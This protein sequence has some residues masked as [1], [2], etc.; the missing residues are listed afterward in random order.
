MFVSPT[1]PL[2]VCIRAYLFACLHGCLLICLNLCVF[3]IFSICLSSLD[4]QFVLFFP[5][6]FCALFN[7]IY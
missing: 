4:P 5:S 1:V 7:E 6:F 3:Q 2:P